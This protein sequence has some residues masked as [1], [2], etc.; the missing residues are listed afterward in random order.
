[1]CKGY[2]QK[3]IC[4]FIFRS[5]PYSHC[6]LSYVIFDSFLFRVLILEMNDCN[7]VPVCCFGVGFWLDFFDLEKILP[8]HKSEK[9][10]SFQNGLQT[11]LK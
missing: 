2:E 10:F 8:F 1:M 6:L 9:Y 5:A 4:H 7:R 3:I 11:S